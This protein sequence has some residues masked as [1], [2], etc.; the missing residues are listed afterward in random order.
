MHG[1]LT[2]FTKC[3]EN[4]EMFISGNIFPDIVSLGIWRSWIC[5]PWYKYENNQQDAL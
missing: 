1:L 2:Y 4:I 5:A 3:D